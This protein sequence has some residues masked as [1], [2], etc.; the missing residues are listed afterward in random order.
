MVVEEQPRVGRARSVAI[1]M[2]TEPPN[3]SSTSPAPTTPAPSAEAIWSAAPPTTGVPALKPVSAAP[4]SET[5]AEDL[6]RGDLARQGGARDMRERD[7]LVVDRVRREIDEAGLERPV[8][9]DRALAREPP[10]DV[11]VG[12]EHGGD[13]GEDLGLVPLDPAQLGGDELL[14]DAVAGLGE[15]GL[16]VDLGAQ[17][18]DLG[19]AARVALLDARPEQAPGASSSTTAGSMP[20][21]PTAA[22]SAGDD[23]ARAHEL[24]HDRADVRPPLRRVFLR[25]AGMGRAQATGRE[26]SASV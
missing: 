15:K 20:V 10:V 22:I 18:L 17:L 12:A 24:A 21:T 26:A 16:L 7:Q 6:V 8:L 5:T 11:V 14:V 25:P 3:L 4:R 23:A 9:L 13:A 19:A 1:R 2:S